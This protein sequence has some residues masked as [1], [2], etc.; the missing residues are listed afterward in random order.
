MKRRT[1]ACNSFPCGLFFSPAGFLQ[2]GLQ[3]RWVGGV[4]AGVMDAGWFLG[5][6]GLVFLPHVPC[7]WW[8]RRGAAWGLA[9]GNPQVEAGSLGPR[10]PQLVRGYGAELALRSGGWVSLPGALSG[11]V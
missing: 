3:V 9:G 2:R 7:N 10:G 5:G 8:L 4:P 1:P 11:R 6:W